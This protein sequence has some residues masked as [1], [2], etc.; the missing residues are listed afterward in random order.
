M[1]TYILS[2]QKNIR[3]LGGL[4]GFEGRNIKFGRLYRGGALNRVNDD[5]IE[6][7]KSFNL[8]HVV[9]FRGDDEF[10]YQPDYHIP[11]VQYVNFSVIQEK[12]KKEDRMHDDGNL[13]W[14]VE[15]NTSGFEHMKQQYRDSIN[16][17]KSQIAY[18]NF[19]KLL[20][21]EDKVVYFHCS[22]G[23][24]RVG[25]AAYFIESILGV[26]QETILEDY[27]FSNVAMEDK[28]QNILGN[29]R[30]KDFYNPF[31]HQKLLDVFAAKEEYLQ[32]AIDEINKNYGDTLSYCQNILGV[33]IDKFRK[34]YLD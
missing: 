19:F 11:G 28:I 22:Q 27:L 15:E 13:L 32:A 31:Y 33:D 17:E 7:L 29:I 1:K 20:Q 6:I 21:E 10:V 12:I 5:D 2:H 34:L 24:D 18:R 4:K 30:F 8:T 14:F 3:D 16:E 25:L 9:D 26:D 23:K